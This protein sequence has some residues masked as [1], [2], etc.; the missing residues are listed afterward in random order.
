M[1]IFGYPNKTPTHAPLLLAACKF[2]DVALLTSAEEFK[3]CEWM[4]V[5]DTPIAIQS[6]IPLFEPFMRRLCENIGPSMTS[7]TVCC[8]ALLCVTYLVL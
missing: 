2:I 5:D 6:N 3:L 7:L 1:R 4:W 8:A